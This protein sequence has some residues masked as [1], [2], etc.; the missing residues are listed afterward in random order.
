ME[1]FLHKV[2]RAYL[3]HERDNMYRYC[4]VFPN[5][6]S[7]AFFLKYLKEQAGEVV[8]L[9][10]V[11]TITDLVHDL[12]DGVEAG[13]FELLFLLYDVYRRILSERHGDDG[14]CS[15][16]PLPDEFD[17]FMYWGDM[18]LADFNDV[19]KYLVDPKE[20][21]K[22][23]RDL[24]EL[25][26]NYLTDEQLSIIKR[27]WGE[28]AFRQAGGDN[29]GDFWRHVDGCG[30]NHRSSRRFLRLW[31]ILYDVYVRFHAALADAGLCYS[32]MSYRKAADR[33]KGIGADELPYSRYV[34]VGFN[35]LSTSELAI[36]ERLKVKGLADFYWDYNSPVLRHK[37]NKAARFLGNYIREFRPMY[38]IGERKITTVPDIRII[39]VPSN[40]G[41]V[42]VASRIIGEMVD[43]GAIAD[44]ANAIDTAVVLPDED[45]FMPVITS[46]PESVTDVN[47]TMGYPLKNTPVAT[48]IGKV[49]AMHQR[50]RY[51]R[52]DY[53]F[54]REDVLNVLSHPIIKSIG[55]DL[56][57]GILTYMADNR[58]FNLPASVIADRFDALG[59]VFAPV[60]P[61]AGVGG[62][63][64][65]VEALLDMLSSAPL[66]DLEKRYVERCR[67]V[68]GELRDVTVRYGVEMS[69]GT[70]FHQMERALF[71]ETINFKGEPLRGLQVM[72]VLETRALDFRNVVMLSMNERVFPRRHYTRSFIP[73]ALRR[74]YGL[75]TVEFQESI[76]AYYFYR[77]ISRA[78]NVV[79][80]FDARNTG[81]KSGEMSRY[82]YQLRYFLP[83]EKVKYEMGKYFIVPGVKNDIE[84]AKDDAVMRRINRYKDDGSG[85]NL[86]ASALKQYIS[87][88]LSFYLER[89]ADIRIPD[90][91]KDYM[92]EG[93]YGE[94]VH[95]IAEKLY[96]EISRER[97]SITCDILDELI[98]DRS[99]RVERQITASI[100][101]YFLKR[102]EGDYTPLS[103]EARIQ[104]DVISHIL[105]SLFREERK[106]TPIEF[107]AGEWRRTVSL[108]ITDDLSVNFTMSI[109][110][111]DQAGGTLRIVDYKTGSDKTVFPDVASLFHPEGREHAKGVFQL[112]LYCY[113]YS[114]ITG[115]DGAI[116]PYLYSI[117][118][119]N[120]THLPPVG[121]GTERVNMPLL[122]YRDVADEFRA[123]LQDLVREI[124]D[125]SVPFR[126]CDDDHACK[127]CKF[128][129]LC[130][131]R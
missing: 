84:V 131:D 34:F 105:K 65:Y 67:A 36:F 57:N 48:L 47:I 96:A 24:K 79:L 51:N 127:Y 82:L 116:Q 75:S 106:F 111:I 110:R 114:A 22:N 72:G 123:G 108:R 55:G 52:G 120:S 124:F 125:P 130:F 31:E 122:D 104:A 95:H 12:S 63:Y 54:F 126:K 20:L 14:G 98:A 28:D 90:E 89:V 40:I 46:I 99:R 76:Y 2:A 86:S 78:E 1:A 37:G 50:G 33:L 53:E 19:D 26:S 73:D 17:K 35:V 41:Q 129:R 15:E 23:V 60:D 7:G 112:L 118:T 44:P 68:I 97:G 91:V 49:V 93:V 128:T 27:Y 109:D 8:M 121:I 39:G 88:P 92:D 81:L 115:Y 16:F 70:F 13:R 62:V 58:L 43:D 107:K 102:G 18:L 100:N 113:A 119:L 117:R 69:A 87:C 11:M 38:D 25:S 74:S 66:D 83:P 77:L 29:A 64:E 3:G 101:E 4:F 42:K 94:I 80:L 45:L 103:G 9:P 61:G 30:R 56:G 59:P 10:G 21:F 71:S 5:K 85:Y 32:G 6:R